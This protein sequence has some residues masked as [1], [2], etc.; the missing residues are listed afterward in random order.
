MFQ[1]AITRKPG[2]NFADGLTRAEGGRPDHALML[3]QHQ[4]YV[5]TLKAL[6]LEVIELEAEP[7]HPDAHFVEDTAVVIPEAAIITRPGAPSRQGEVKSIEKVLSRFR[8]LR[9]IEPPGTLDGGDVLQAGRRFFIGLS[10]RTNAEGAGQLGTVLESYGYPWTTVPVGE[11]LHLKSGVNWVGENSL[12][13]TGTF[14]D[15]Q[16]FHEFDKIV[17]EVGEDYAANTLW[18]NDS[19]L[20]AAGYPK[21]REKLEALGSKIIE[22]DVS[23][24]QKM[25]GGLTCM[26][27]RF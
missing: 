21:T 17:V 5:D 27:I 16:V 3:K 18:I 2:E 24:A 1:Y 9:R 25:D 8:E 19:L 11:G 6:G 10:E 12:L 23:E 14:K 13:V 7:A 20:M 15:R 26:S 22:L 4:A